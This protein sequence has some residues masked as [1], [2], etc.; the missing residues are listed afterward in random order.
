MRDFRVPE[1]LSHSSVSSYQEC[2]RRYLLENRL[3]LSTRTWW[4][5]LGGT[6]FHELTAEL[7]RWDSLDD[8]YPPEATYRNAFLRFLDS[9]ESEALHEGLTPV[10]SGQTRTRICKT[11]GPNRK[12]RE[13]WEHWGPIY[14][15]Q[16]VNWRRES[17]WTVATMPDG[18]PAIEVHLDVEVGGWKTVAYV[19]RLFLDD[20][21]RLAIVDLKSGTAPDSHDQLRDYATKLYRQYGLRA[22]V[23]FYYHAPSGGP[24][25]EVLL[26]AGEYDDVL[27]ETYSS[28]GDAIEKMIFP[29]VENNFCK[30]CPVREWCSAVGGARSGEVPLPNPVIKNRPT[31]GE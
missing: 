8:F 22:D 7:D 12:D 18:M 23:G 2:P 30:S 15:E 19:D 31:E 27:D 11:G 9:A 20:T 14:V 13:W 21:G 6:A 24:L 5:N 1:H 25:R 17:Q 26:G 10:P 3:K 28:V 4:A 16:Y 29:A